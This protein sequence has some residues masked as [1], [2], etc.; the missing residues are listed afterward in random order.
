MLKI[1]DCYN[2]AIGILVALLSG[3]FGQYW[4][5]FGIYLLFNII[6]W[7]TGWYKARKLKKES[8]RVGLIGLVKKLGYWALI[9]VA[10]LM[11]IAIC[12]IGKIIGIDE[13]P[14]ISYLGWF[15]LASL[16][17]NEVRSISENLVEA[18][19]KKIPKV[20]TKGLE[21]VENVFNKDDIEIK[22]RE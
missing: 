10:F 11:P 9:I 14:F 6:D 8:S 2:A 15:V 17:V 12:G 16:I 20:F 4:Y 19:Y 7:L 13:I 5:L 22:Q 21:V 3:L 1:L 18:G